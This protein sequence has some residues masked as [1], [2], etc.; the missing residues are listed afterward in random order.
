MLTTWH[1]QQGSPWH[2][3]LSV[4]W[5]CSASWQLLA[6]EFSLI[7]VKKQR[8]CQM[9]WMYQIYTTK[10]AKQG[11]WLTRHCS[12]VDNCFDSLV[13]LVIPPSCW[14]MWVI[15]WSVRGKTILHHWCKYLLVFSEDQLL[16]LLTSFNWKC[17]LRTFYLGMQSWGSTAVNERRSLPQQQNSADYHTGNF[18]WHLSIKLTAKVC[19]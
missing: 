5:A 2:R 4:V 11:I 6:K 19:A 17:F 8:F 15:I 18:Y 9:S 1:P 7:T 10:N 3:A 16:H 13:H 14:E 12:S